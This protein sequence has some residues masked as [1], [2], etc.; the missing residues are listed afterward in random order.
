MGRHGARCKSSGRDASLAGK[1][2]SGSGYRTCNSTRACGPSRF[3]SSVRVT[4][5]ARQGTAVR[6]HIM[7]GDLIDVAAPWRGESTLLAEAGISSGRAPFNARR[8]EASCPFPLLSSCRYL[9]AMQATKAEPPGQKG[10]CDD[11][12]TRWRTR[13]TRQQCDE[14]LSQPEGSTRQACASVQGR[15]R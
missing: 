14:T 15:A 7:L 1:G 8:L 4:R 5:P 11:G 6:G 12:R 10:R 3:A 9:R 2:R 13:G